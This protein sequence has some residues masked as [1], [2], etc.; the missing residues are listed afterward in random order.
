MLAESGKAVALLHGV[1]A[2]STC[3]ET[4][5][6]AEMMEAA[7]ILE[8]AHVPESWLMTPEKRSQSLS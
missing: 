5:I 4:H 7:Y 6:V 8:A 3:F 1:F 2:I